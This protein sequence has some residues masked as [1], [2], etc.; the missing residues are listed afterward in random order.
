MSCS[1]LVPYDG[2]SLAQRAMPV[3]VEL[4]RA[5]GGRVVIVRAT[6]PDIDSLAAETDTQELAHRV[7][8][9]GV[10]VTVRV[11]AGTPV[12]IVSEESRT[13][14]PDW[15]VL[16]SHGQSGPGRWVY[17]S[18][19]DEL[20]RKATAPVVLV[21]VSQHAHWPDGHRARLLVPLDGSPVSEVILRAAGS[22]ARLL[23]ATVS[24]LRVV[25]PPIP[26]P[27]LYDQCAPY[28]EFDAHCELA[29]A[30]AYLRAASATLGLKAGR[31][32]HHAVIG[33]P[34]VSIPRM[35]REQRADLVVL[36]RSGEGA[37][38]NTLGSTAL[39]TVQLAGVPI[40]LVPAPVAAAAEPTVTFDESGRIVPEGVAPDTQ[41]SDAL[42]A[43]APEPAAVGAMR[44]EGP[45]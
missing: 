25:E 8:R 36:A 28:V 29:A 39:G 2:S 26:G 1:V 43:S 24:L 17:G 11:R 18:V 10:P 33:F 41:W 22:L 35:A 42:E 27:Y 3:A 5:S 13:W 16:A 37:T 19:A 4:A 21:P 20:L 31:A 14:E 32:E 15:I 44:A 12:Q 45:V 38:A 6:S 34:G 40:V 7:R 30:R 23:D 9:S